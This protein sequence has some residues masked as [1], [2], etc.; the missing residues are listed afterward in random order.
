MEY[1]CRFGDPETEVLLRLLD[2]DLYTI[3]MACCDERLHSV[4]VR[5]SSDYVCGVVLAAGGYPHSYP[6]GNTIAVKT[7]GGRVLC[8]TSKALSMDEARNLAYDT[9]N[10]IDFEGKTFRKD[11]GLKYATKRTLAYADSGVNISEGNLLIE[12]IKSICSRTKLPST[13]CIGG[14]GSVIDLSV[15]G[16]SNAQLV[17]GMDGVGTKIA[18]A[19]EMGDYSGIGYDLVGMCVNDVLCHCS[20]PLA[21]LDYYV[22][23]QLNA[24]TAANIIDSIAS[25]CQSSNC[26]LVGGETAEMPGVY[27]RNQWDLAGVCVA[28]RDPKWPLLPLKEKITDGNVLIGI[29]SN[30]LHSNGYSLDCL[31]WPKDEIFQWL[32]NIGPVEPCEMM[33]T[34]NCGI[35]MVLV[36]KDEH[37]NQVMELLTNNGEKAFIIGKTDRRLKGEDQIE[38]LN[39][40]SCF[41]EKYSSPVP[42]KKINVAILISGT[43]SNMMR[44]IE[45]SLEPMSECRIAVVISN[46]SNAKGILTAQSMGIHTKVIPSK[47]SSSREAFEALITQELEL[48][49][50]DLICLAGFMRILTASFVRRWNGH[51][52][53]IHPSLL[54]A[55]KGSQA[56]PLALQHKVKIAGCTV[57]FVNG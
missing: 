39:L 32:K 19:D 52:I 6:K 46:V 26:A 22:C 35:G 3:L 51:I 42:K 34:F 5:W 57:H 9:V 41:S 48:C 30:G 31:S 21:F 16:F 23:G 12:K 1:N 40:R 53:N 4:D 55:F 14:F 11:I 45:S 36:T 18:I 25:A 20:Q 17:I 43:G 27:S 8:V 44:L 10:K 37:T 56:V 28:V 50:V 29:K 38:L 15:A 33:R 49:E 7:N 24:S 54:P 13:D 2:S 47:G